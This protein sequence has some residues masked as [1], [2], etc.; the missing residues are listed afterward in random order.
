MNTF[1]I[2]KKN[3]TVLI[4][5]VVCLTLAGSIAAY[6]VPV[7]QVARTVNVQ[8]ITTKCCV[9]LNPTV[10]VTEP[11]TVTPVIVTWGADYNTSGTAQFGLSVNGGSCVA[12]GPFVVQEPV[13]IPGSNSITVSG[14][15]QWVVIPSDGLVKGKNRFQ[16]CGGGF[17]ATET[18]NI[19][20][21]T[22]TVQISK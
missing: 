18:I 17:G 21:S 10:T 15:H 12:Y 19:G 1:S 13:L 3:N 14:T 5:A 16:L 22:L 11:A 7:G 8:T 6:A 2:T 4:A 20:F 9:L